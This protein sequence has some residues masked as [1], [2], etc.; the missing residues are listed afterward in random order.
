M[1]LN[2][3]MIG[4]L[5][6][7]KETKR[8]F[9]DQLPGRPDVIVVDISHQ[10]RRLLSQKSMNT[11][12]KFRDEAARF[13]KDLF[14]EVNTVL[15]VADFWPYVPQCKAV[16]AR[17]RGRSKDGEPVTPFSDAEM[18]EDS[19]SRRDA[20]LPTDIDRALMTPKLK[21]L[22]TS[23]FAQAALGACVFPV[24][25]KPYKSIIVDGALEHFDPLSAV[26]P[27]PGV[28]MKQSCNG[29]ELVRW[30]RSLPR[31]GE[32]DLRW[33]RW[34]SSFA[35]IEEGG[36]Y[37][38]H[39]PSAPTTILL[40]V[41]DSDSLVVALLN[42]ENF[43]VEDEFNFRLFMHHGSR[44]RWCNYLPSY[45]TTSEA[46]EAT[47]KTGCMINV[48]RFWDIINED[49]GVVS[50]EYPKALGVGNPHLVFCSLLLLGGSDYVKHVN[51]QT[52]VVLGSSPFR[53][54]GPMKILDMFFDN[55]A[56]R[57]DFSSQILVGE[58]WSQPGQLEHHRAHTHLDEKRMLRF[59]KR[60]YAKGLQKY[61]IADP[62]GKATESFERIQAAIYKKKVQAHDKKRT[63]GEDGKV[64]STKPSS[65]SSRGGGD[66][67]NLKKDRIT[68]E[69]EG[70][71]VL[72]RLF[73]QVEMM[74]NG[75]TALTER[76]T[77]LDVHTGSDLS[78]NG[79]RVDPKTGI[80][81][82]VAKVYMGE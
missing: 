46:R 75:W 3:S 42:M 50:N 6:K 21:L 11:W 53:N 30:K 77:D 39:D 13:V 70:I 10:M 72:R 71:A 57:E 36:T 28:F 40:D 58:Q 22:F 55:P 68:T 76:H 54:M 47:Q 78:L 63:K 5:R 27:E 26:M 61:G 33:V 31:I 15:L 62:R 23:E 32:G 35:S 79:W 80:V 9:V 41:N 44:S 18:R 20:G 67:V 17:M 38:R 8:A 48:S 59:V 52:G 25:T 65:S 19:I 14:K 34:L 4:S 1:G 45:R 43:L 66:V 51:G 16:E 69:D 2:D 12:E 64:T 29:G 82:A 74:R 24:N 49:F 81:V 73:Y 37:G 7:R 60:F 56:A